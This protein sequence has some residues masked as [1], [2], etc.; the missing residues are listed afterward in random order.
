MKIAFFE[1]EHWEVD[2]LKDSLKDHEVDFFKDRLDKDN[3]PEKRDYDVLLVFSNCE[4]TKDVIDA[5][6]NLKLIATRSTGYDHI[7]LATA[8]AKGIVVSNVPNYGQNTVA[9]FA[10]GLILTLSRKIFNSYDR[11]RETGSFDFNG[12]QGFDLKGKTIGVV[13]TGKIGK[14]VVK[15][16]Q[17]FEMNIIAFDAYPDEAF[18]TENHVKYVSFEELLKES[19]I[20]T[21]HVPELP[22]TFH[23]LNMENINLVKKGALVINTARGSVIETEALVKALHSGILGGAGLDV[24]EEEVSTKDELEFLINGKPEE[25]DLKIILSNHMLIDMDN[26]VITPHTAFFTK[27]AMAR[28]LDT[29]VSSINAFIAGSPQNEVKQKK[30]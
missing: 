2:Y 5:F 27:E 26:V 12:L 20:I 8:E 1:T 3:L 18:A 7:D 10:F 13:G 22:S 4:L 9:E 23:M 29:T 17:G 6:P 25:H 16:A 30:A 19:D 28:I 15:M 24:L 14:H 11:I 21:F